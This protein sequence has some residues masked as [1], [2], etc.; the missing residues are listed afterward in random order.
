LTAS[1]P[2]S[3]PVQRCEHWHIVNQPGRFPDHAAQANTHIGQDAGASGRPGQDIPGLIEP[4]QPS[5][6]SAGCAC[7]EPVPVAGRH[8][9]VRGR[10]REPPCNGSHR[11]GCF[12]IK[13]IQPKKKHF[14]PGLTGSAS[15]LVDGG[16]IQW[17]SFEHP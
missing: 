16:A 1:W 10:L 3:R 7:P 4:T 8:F 17:R 14:P 5:G 9:P 11:A 15:H 6:A 2:G 12:V 13:A